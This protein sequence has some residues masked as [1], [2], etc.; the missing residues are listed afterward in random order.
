MLGCA[1]ELTERGDKGGEVRGRV[2]V[3]ALG[4]RGVGEH[5]LERVCERGRDE[6]C[7]RD[8]QPLSARRRPALAQRLSRGVHA[9]QGVAQDCPDLVGVLP[10]AV[11][12]QRAVRGGR[13]G[14]NLIPS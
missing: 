9:Q 7:R 6:V 5:E 12:E 11:V 4:E 8:E 3:E 14:S 10:R 13:H 1:R 2:G